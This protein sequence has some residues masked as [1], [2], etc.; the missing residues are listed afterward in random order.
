VLTD[1]GGSAGSGLGDGALRRGF[2]S[3]TGDDDTKDTAEGG[4]DWL[5]RFGSGSIARLPI[6]ASVEDALSWS[7][8]GI[9]DSASDSAGNARR[10]RLP[11]SE[12]PR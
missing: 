9:N 6:L 12:N 11:G 2:G 8:P 1:A 4:A 3:S 10:G 5:N 7:L